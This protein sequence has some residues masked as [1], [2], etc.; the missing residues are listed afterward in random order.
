MVITNSR[1]DIDI[2]IMNTNRKIPK[3]I[4]LFIPP[5]TTSGSHEKE[6]HNAS[7]LQNEEDIEWEKTNDKNPLEII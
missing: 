7:E 1:E 3:S 2:D 5:R 4:P 6:N